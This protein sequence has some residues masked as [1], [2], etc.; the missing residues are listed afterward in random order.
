MLK[1]PLDFRSNP[2]SQYMQVVY[3]TSQVKLQF[4]TEFQWSTSAPSKA[5]YSVLSLYEAGVQSSVYPKRII[6]GTLYWDVEK[7]ID[8]PPATWLKAQPC[9][10][11]YAVCLYKEDLFKQ[12][13]VNK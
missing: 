3:P 7:E 4:P 11:I 12:V 6:V 9:A 13:S 1:V 10:H 2:T 5:V 8:G